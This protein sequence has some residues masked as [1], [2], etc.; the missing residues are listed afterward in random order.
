M[1]TGQV[2]PLYF[3]E[4]PALSQFVAPELKWDLGLQKQ[5]EAAGGGEGAMDL[6][7]QQPQEDPVAMVQQVGMGDWAPVPAT[8]ETRRAWALN[9]MTGLGLQKVA[10]PAALVPPAP[11]H[12]A[13]VPPAPAPPAAAG[14]SSGMT[15]QQ[16]AAIEASSGGGPA[17]PTRAGSKPPQRKSLSKG[18]RTST[19]TSAPAG[20]AAQG[21]AITAGKQLSSRARKRLRP[22]IKW[23]PDHR[24]LQN[25]Y[26]L[27]NGKAPYSVPEQPVCLS[28]SDPRVVGAAK[29]M[30]P[31]SDCARF[32]GSQ[33]D[34]LGHIQ[35]EHH[36][37]R[38]PPLCS[39]GVNTFVSAKALWDH[40][41]LQHHIKV[42][43]VKNGPKVVLKSTA[44]DPR[45]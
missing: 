19:T 23:E 4:V 2:D 28:L 9:I 12:P 7:L 37:H 42:V 11:A 14:R 32:C 20:V 41:D 18:S 22:Y 8:A 5:V 24:Q 35:K 39:C 33:L 29:W 16:W 17:K 1:G 3:G 34:C 21:A 15:L 25:S 44:R 27:L 31:Q 45:T 13:P 6:P 10:N 26:L 43:E 30:C 40:L 38:S 36:P